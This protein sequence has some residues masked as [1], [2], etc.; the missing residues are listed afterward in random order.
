M[1]FLPL[2]ARYR[3]VVSL[4][5]AT[6]LWSA[7]AAV[8]APIPGLFNTGVGTNGALLPG[9][10]VDPHYRL[11]QSA[12]TSAP[13]PNSI[14][15]NEGW[16]IA[17]TGGGPWLANGPSSKW[18]SPLASQATGNA[19]GD[20]RYR[21]VFD[22][23]GLEPSTAVITGRWTSDNA[24]AGIFLNGAATGITY[25]GNF[26]AF[27]AMFTINSGFIDG[28]NTL[29]FVVNNAGTTVNPTGFRAEISGTAD[30]QPPPGTPPTI[31]QQPASQTNGI[32]ESATFSVQA[33]G[34]RPF[35]YQWRRNGSPIPGG[36]NSTYTINGLS[37]A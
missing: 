26:G 37:G 25:D 16:P 28:T 35:S 36:T 30:S 27:S 12:D 33:S 6:L 34:S 13:G 32:G 15:M 22:L 21:I 5:I 2:Q 10:S 17:P 14:V 24:G 29:D 9:G 19:A 4:I 23:T 31:T 11:I 20:Y 1:L 7:L 8:A 3:S 18:I